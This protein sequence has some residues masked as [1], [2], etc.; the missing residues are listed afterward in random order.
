MQNLHAP[1][2]K[3]YEQYCVD[4]ANQKG[5][6]LPAFHGTRIQRGYGSGSIFK[7]LFRWAMAHLQ[8]GAKV[9]GK[10]A[11]Q[12]GGNVAQELLTEITLKRHS[13]NRRNKL[14]VT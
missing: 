1:N 8:Q 13:A 11:L 10:K 7:S 4:Q 2:H 9:I 6:N 3:F 5:G 14:Q 12:T